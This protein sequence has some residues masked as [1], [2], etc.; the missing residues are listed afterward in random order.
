[1]PMLVYNPHRRPFMPFSISLLKSTTQP[2]VQS[3]EAKMLIKAAERIIR[4]VHEDSQSRP[5]R[6]E[7]PGSLETLEFEADIDV[8]VDRATRVALQRA[9]IAQNQRD[10]VDVDL[11]PLP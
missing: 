10:W 4:K 5:Q 6:P 11:P 3:D 2:P 1:M 9:F 8:P 7:H